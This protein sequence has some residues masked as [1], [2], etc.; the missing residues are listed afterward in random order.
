MLYYFK[1]EDAPDIAENIAGGSH[2][3]D[4][5]SQQPAV[6]VEEDFGEDDDPKIAELMMAHTLDD[7]QAAQ[8][9][10][11]IHRFGIDEEDAV[12]RVTRNSSV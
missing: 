4:D 1:Q 10:D 12:E 11:L 7:D 9:R 5:E 8:A 3:A 2:D 6:E